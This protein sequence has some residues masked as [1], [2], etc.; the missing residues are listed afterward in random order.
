VGIDR[1]TAAELSSMQCSCGSND[2]DFTDAVEISSLN[3]EGSEWRARGIVHIA[4]CVHGHCITCGRVFEAAKRQ[5]PITF[6]ELICPQCE[7]PDFLQFKV[8]GVTKVEEG[9]EFVVAVR[10]THCNIMNIL[11]R[12]LTGLISAVGIE[13]GLTGIS[14]SVKKGTSKP[15]A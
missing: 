12:I 8:Q 15:A 11:R 14:I 1:E 7:K 10:C 9:F 2:L 3:I 4:Y 13:I 6:P 5:I